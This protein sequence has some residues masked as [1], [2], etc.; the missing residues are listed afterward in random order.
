MLSL[1][2]QII[3]LIEN[4]E[5][6]LNILCL[7]DR[8]GVALKYSLKYDFDKENEKIKLV[9]NEYLKIGHNY[10]HD[11]VVELKNKLKAEIMRLKIS[12]YIKKGK[13]KK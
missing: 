1:D 13:S 2:H 10:D 8:Y 9:I 3:T 11:K 12:D 7:V 5:R 6:Y 4:H